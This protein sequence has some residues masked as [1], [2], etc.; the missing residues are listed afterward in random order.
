MDWGGGPVWPEQGQ[1][2]QGGA[3]TSTSGGGSEHTFYI[4]DC[5]ARKESNGW[6]EKG[7]NVLDSESFGAPFMSL[8]MSMELCSAWPGWLH[9]AVLLD[10]PQAYLPEDGVVE[11]TLNQELGA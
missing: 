1:K 7:Q 6:A 10:L 3:F 11:R 2:H 4:F 8:P 5:R 9:T